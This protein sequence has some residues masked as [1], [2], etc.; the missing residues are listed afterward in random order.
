MSRLRGELYDLSERRFPGLRARHYRLLSRLPAEGERSSRAAASGLTKQALAQTLVPLQ[1]GGYVEVVPDPHDRR[2]RV[3][4]LTDRGR[5]VDAALRE[6][7][8]RGRGGVGRPGGT[9]ALCHRPGGL[10][11]AHRRRPAEGS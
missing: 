1:D 10:Q 11:P 5:E 4:R 7:A 2:A 9:G 3:L 6:P 8:G